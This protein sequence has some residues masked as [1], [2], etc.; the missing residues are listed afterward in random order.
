MVSQE[1][2]SFDDPG[3]DLFGIIVGDG[4]SLLE[5]LIQKGTVIR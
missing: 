5:N 4:K 2:F 3:G 1:D